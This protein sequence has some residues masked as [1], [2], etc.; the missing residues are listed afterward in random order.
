MITSTDLAYMAEA[1]QLA[2]RG[3]YTTTPNPN[4]GCVIVKNQQ[5]IGKGWHKKAGTGHA[6]VNALANLT[7]AASSG[8]T[9]Y[10]TLEPCSH[11]GRT[12]PCA[13]RLVEAGVSRVVV[14]MLDTNPQVSGNG[15]KILEEAGIEVEVGVLEAECR[16]LNPGFFSIMERQRPFVQIKL[17]ASLDGKTAL[18]NGESKWITGP[19]AR[20]DVQTYRA[21]A[22]AI[23]TSAS[24]VLQDD[25]SMNVRQEQLNFNYPLD[26]TNTNIRQP[27]VVVLDGRARLKPEVATSLKLFNTGAH[28]ILIQN[29]NSEY[30]EQAF[31]EKGFDQVTVEKLEYDPTSGFDLNDVMSVCTQLQFNTV[32]VEAGG[33]L[34]ASFIHEKIADELIVY[35]APKIMGQG[36][37]DVIPLGPF[38]EMNQTVSLTTKDM[39]QVGED[40]RLTYT[41]SN[42]ND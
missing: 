23:L 13:L 1:V 24:T 3:Q 35:I 39:R 40:I 4:V 21:K 32:W 12:P 9:A 7:K 31:S 8:A 19:A 18:H 42:K 11:Y 6:E 34:A 20:A 29:K 37:F 30:S 14:G 2:K 28:V 5:I 26:E 22:S 27:H 25:A 38:S 33:R 41:L 36:G 10:V 16:A 17:A 15:I